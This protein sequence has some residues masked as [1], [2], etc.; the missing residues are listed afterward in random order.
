MPDHVYSEIVT[1][2]EIEFKSNPFV[3]E[4]VKTKHYQTLI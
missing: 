4:E 1:L 3:L 2:N